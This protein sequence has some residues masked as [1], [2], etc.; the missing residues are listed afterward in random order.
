MTFL[1]RL[2]NP[3]V[4]Y[5]TW[6]GR[7]KPAGMFS[8]PLRIAVV[9]DDPSVRR[10]LKRLLGTFGIHADVFESG[11]EF[12]CAAPW[13]G[14]DCLIVDLHMPRLTALDVLRALPKI[15]SGLP[16]LVVT[17]EG[18]PE[19][20][21]QCIAAGA[22]EVLIKPIDERVLMA[23]IGRAVQSENPAIVDV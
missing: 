13:N 4:Q 15:R 21:S 23:A 17:A 22:L 8:R 2:R 11:L 6:V 20:C 16:T 14:L 10:A 3:K 7:L 18:D 9:D 5:L 12:L 19:T 1:Q